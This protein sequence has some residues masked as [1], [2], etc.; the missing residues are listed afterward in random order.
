LTTGIED[1][2]ENKKTITIYP[3][4]S[5]TSIHVECKNGFQIYASTGQ[6]VKQNN[7]ATTQIDIADLPAGIY[8]LRADRLEGRFI[9]TE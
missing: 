9:K 8:I 3:N 2:I 4:P 1:L 5:N 7:Q 6:L